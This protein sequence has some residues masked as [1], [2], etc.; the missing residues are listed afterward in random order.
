MEKKIIF[1]ALGGTVAGM[2]VASAIFMGLLGGMAEQWMKDNQACLNEMN[3]MFWIIA[4]VVQSVFITI[5][6]V[7]LNIDNFRSG[8]IAGAWM[9]FF[10]VLWFGLVTVSTFKAYTWGW[11]P[12]DLVGNT[13]TGAIA[14]GVIGLILGK[15]K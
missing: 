1:G 5:L 10:I 11:L 12:Y 2:V 13:I 6:F 14:G 4:S 7:K 8:A 3:P 15:M 9:S